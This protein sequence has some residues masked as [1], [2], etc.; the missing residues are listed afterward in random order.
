MVN[1]RIKKKAEAEPGVWTSKLGHHYFSFIFRFYVACRAVA[2]CLFRPPEG[3]SVHDKLQATEHRSV[4]VF[5]VW[6]LYE[7][8]YVSFIPLKSD[9]KEEAQ[10]TGG[11]EKKQDDRVE[12]INM[13]YVQ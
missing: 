9:H 11:D 2:N 6:T 4:S 8:L 5:F 13:E 12:D 1:N 3:Y 7:C 10:L